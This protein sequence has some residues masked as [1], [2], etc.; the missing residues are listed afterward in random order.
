MKVV[1]TAVL[2]ALLF[3]PPTVTAA[4]I[5]LDICTS[6]PSSPCI[7]SVAITIRALKPDAQPIRRQYRTSLGVKP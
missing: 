2:A 7:D 5:P 3:L 4:T 6:L 1:G